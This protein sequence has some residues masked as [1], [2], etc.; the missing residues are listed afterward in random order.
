MNEKLVIAWNSVVGPEDTVYYVGDFSM[1]ARSVEL[2]TK[3]LNGRKILVA[4]NHDFVHPAHRRSKTPENRAKWV[5][6]YI[7]NGWSEVHTQIE[8][9]IPGIGMV[10]ICHLPYLEPNSNE[11][12]RYT[13]HRPI[14]DGRWLLC[15]HVHDK[16]KVRNKMINVGVD[17]NNF[18]PVSLDEIKKIIEATNG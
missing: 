7:D 3:R 8:L 9:D 12:K 2:Y 15:G 13:S 11:D 10:N 14:D 5:Q 16:W 4:G 6:M 1:A 18:L 17:A